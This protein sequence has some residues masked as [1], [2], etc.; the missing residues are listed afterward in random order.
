MAEWSAARSMKAVQSLALSADCPHQQDEICWRLSNLRLNRLFPVVELWADEAGAAWAAEIGLRYSA[1]HQLP[2]IPDELRRIWCI[3]KLQAMAAQREP[4]L[5]V[6]GDVFLQRL[7][8]QFG[9]AFVVQSEETH[10]DAAGRWDRLGFAPI[11]K[12]PELRS[13]NF[14]VVGGTAWQELAAAAESILACLHDNCALVAGA[15]RRCGLPM[16]VE[17]IWLPAIMAA[18]GFQPACLLRADH[19]QADAAAAGYCH[20]QSRSK[21]DPRILLAWARESGG[22]SCDPADN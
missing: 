7:L 11:P 19:L 1:V 9:E 14:G 8:P 2:Y 22:F 15:C 20:A 6:D 18:A 3:S 21:S 10:V 16:L 4:F 13:Y 12:P 17:Q 5:H